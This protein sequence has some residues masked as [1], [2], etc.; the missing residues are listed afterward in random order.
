M[1][2]PFGHMLITPSGIVAGLRGR[3]PTRRCWWSM[4]APLGHF[5]RPTALPRRNPLRLWADSPGNRPG[6]GGWHRSSG[7][8]PALG[9]ILPCSRPGSPGGSACFGGAALPLGLSPGLPTTASRACRQ[10]GVTRCVT[11]IRYGPSLS[12]ATGGPRCL[13]GKG[14]G[15]GARPH[16]VNLPILP[17]RRSPVAKLSAHSGKT[18]GGGRIRTCDLQVMSL[19]SYRAA[20]PRHPWRILLKRAGAEAPGQV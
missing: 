10:S 8:S 5:T 3:R 9:R 16:R 1:L 7:V 6:R 15:H 2:R 20:P 4:T 17:S 19:T 12:G 14:R 18:G 11:L 13:D